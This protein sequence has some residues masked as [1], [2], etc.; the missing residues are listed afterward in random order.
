MIRVSPRG[1]AF[2]VFVL[3]N[4]YDSCDAVHEAWRLQFNPGGELTGVPLP[5][6]TYAH[7]YVNRLLSRDGV[8]HMEAE[9][10]LLANPRR[11]A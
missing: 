3:V 4:A 7:T 6:G 11:L 5:L 10:A 1:S 9:M 2:S 8:A